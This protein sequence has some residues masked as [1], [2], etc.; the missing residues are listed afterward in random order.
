M[1]FNVF[2]DAPE[3]ARDGPREQAALSA[4]GTVNISVL[5]Y[6]YTSDAWCASCRNIFYDGGKSEHPMYKLNGMDTRE[7][8]GFVSGSFF[9][10][11]MEQ[12]SNCN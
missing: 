5:T 11:S 8:R 6:R 2:Y 1:N 9:G 12:G 3:N 7:M 10:S 4:S